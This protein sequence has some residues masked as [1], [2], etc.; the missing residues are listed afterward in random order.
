MWWAS[1]AQAG[2]YTV[3]SCRGPDGSAISAAAW[4]TQAIDAASGD[5]TFTDDCASGGSLR[6][7]ATPSGTIE[8]RE[9]V[10][11]A[12]FEPPPGTVIS[13][14]EIWRYVAAADGPKWPERVG[15]EDEDDYAASLE[16]WIIGVG[17]INSDCAARRSEPECAIGTPDVPLDDSNLVSKDPGAEEAPLIEKLGFWVRCVRLGCEPPATSPPAIFELFRSAIS[18]EDDSAPTVDRL[19]GPL[20]EAAPVAGVAHLFVTATDVGGGIAGFRFSVD[21]G[22]PQ[23]VTM[24]DGQGGCEEPFSMPQPCT[25]TATRGFAVDTASLA[26]GGHVISGSVVDAAGNSTSF[27]PISFTVASPP[28]S[29]A[30]QGGSSPDNGTPAVEKPRLRL[31][32]QARL[33][34]AGKPVRLRGTLRT[35]SGVPVVGAR[36]EVELTELGSKRRGRTRVIRTDAEGRFE[37]KVNGGGARTVVVSYAPRLGGAVTRSAKTLVR[38]RLGLRLRS[39][40]RR[41]RVGQ[42]VRFFG[43]LRGAGRAARGAT[44]EI[45]AISG[46]RWTT[47]DTVTAGRGGA[48]SWTHRFRYVE[49]N[50]IFSFRAVVLRTPGWPWS[51]VRSRRLELVIKGPPR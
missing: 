44:V 7:E 50:A 41:I 11:E 28:A 45:Q 37:F 26:P 39:R 24:G 23:V 9:P 10:G 32:P 22:A 25:P 27:G 49:R 33:L 38:T 36:L 21:G 16:E 34:P 43:R 35:S 31:Q 17:N 47:V 30:G 40:P 4:R 15:Q 1:P 2:E 3:W 5:V 20:A 19:E 13:S 48:F 51:T 6:I 14:Y 29:V 46:G 42:A 18:I 8:N 12:V